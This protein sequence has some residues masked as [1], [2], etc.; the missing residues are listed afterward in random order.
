MIEINKPKLLQPKK[1]FVFK[2]VFGVESHKTVLV[3]LLN[4]ILKGKPLI[5]SI[6]LDTTEISKNSEDGKDV[7]LDILAKSNDGTKINIEMQC[8]DKG[9]LI[10]RTAFYQS[11]TM[12]DS[13]KSGENYDAIPDMISIWITDY[14]ATNRKN[15][16]NEIVYMYE[17]NEKD[18]TVEVASTKFRTLIIEL[19]K[20]DFNN[21]NSSD[22]FDVWMMFIKNPES[23]PEEF[24]DIKEI[25][26]AMNELTL[27]SNNPEFKAEYEARLRVE[28]DKIAEISTAEIKGEE[29]GL[30]KGEE[31]GLE[32]GGKKKAI[33]MATEMLNDGQ[34]LKTIM[35]YTKLTEDEIEALR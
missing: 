13:L 2:R 20:I 25:K 3:S 18:L 27:L 15:H 22:M 28:N 4:S 12:V 31:I 16:T 11:R 19:T 8:T 34:S 7:R 33:E 9:K 17:K 10:N 35:K 23:I 14:N 24:L 32:K 29:R 5:E 1:D 6:T 30:I 21:I 26:E